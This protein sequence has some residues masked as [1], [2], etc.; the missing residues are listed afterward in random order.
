LALFST[1]IPDRTMG[2]AP[3]CEEPDGETVFR[4]DEESCT[5]ISA[6]LPSV[7]VALDLLRDGTRSWAEEEF[8]EL[9]RV[10]SASREEL[11]LKEF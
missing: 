1:S 10:G 9:G 4:L 6:L 2:L 7:G 3:R 11:L 8:L 5:D